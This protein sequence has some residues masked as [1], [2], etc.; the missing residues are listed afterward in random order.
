MGGPETFESRLDVMVSTVKPG[1]ILTT[2]N[3]G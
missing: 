3:G 1:L 2:D